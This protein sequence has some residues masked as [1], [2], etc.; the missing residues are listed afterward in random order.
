MAHTALQF[1]RT[2]QIYNF[3]FGGFCHIVMARSET[4][5]QSITL[6]I[7]KTNNGIF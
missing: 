7:C 2:A 1:V 5:Q 6:T 3:S 4:T